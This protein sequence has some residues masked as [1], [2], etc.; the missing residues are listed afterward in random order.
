[1]C[2]RSQGAKYFRVPK[3]QMAY[4]NTRYSALHLII[5]I[6]VIIINYYHHHYTSVE[7][8][9]IKRHLKGYLS[10]STLEV[11]FYLNTFF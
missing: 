9:V 6:T 3:D 8:L 5:F 4:V 2:P 1:M 7:S 10:S 11:F